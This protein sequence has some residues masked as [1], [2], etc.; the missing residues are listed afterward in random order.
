MALLKRIRRGVSAGR[1]YLQK[2]RG[3]DRLS[4]RFF[5]LRSDTE[6]LLRPEE[7][8]AFV[9]TPKGTK[10]KL[11]NVAELGFYGVEIK[12]S[13]PSKYGLDLEPIQ[14]SN[15]RTLEVNHLPS[16]ETRE[17]AASFGLRFRLREK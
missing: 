9:L 12:S 13:H 2:R 7:R 16:Q 11:R 17:V 14:K 4:G 15:P 1:H 10:I 5:R 3:V 8:N 6:L